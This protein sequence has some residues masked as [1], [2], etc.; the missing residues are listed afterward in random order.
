M[1]TANQALPLAPCR[2]IR[3]LLPDDGTDRRLL[4]ALYKD[5]GI[6]RASSLAVRAVGALS[7]VKTRKGRLPEPE[8]AR[9]VNI[10]VDADQ[11]DDLFDFVCQV[12]RIDRPGGGLAYLQTS[13]VSTPFELPAI[14]D[15]KA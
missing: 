8:L 14:A 13:G 15:E 3:V 5:K 12:A 7:A 1:N 9:V 11:A 2:R 4:Q 6:T 10:V